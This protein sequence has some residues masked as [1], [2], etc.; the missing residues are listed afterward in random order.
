[1]F[2]LKRLFFKKEKKKISDSVSWQENGY[3]GRNDYLGITS[4]ELF[5]QSEGTSECIFD[6][7]MENSELVKNNKYLDNKY[8]NKVERYKYRSDNSFTSR[9]CFGCGSV[10]STRMCKY[11][12]NIK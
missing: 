11:C 3:I 1:M 10:V 6:I 9:I 5:T 2:N 7:C 12:G 8:F 4:G